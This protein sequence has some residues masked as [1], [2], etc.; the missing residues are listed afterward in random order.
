[1]E[2]KLLNLILLLLPLW[3]IGQQCGA[4]MTPLSLE[5]RVNTAQKIVEGRIIESE[6]YWDANR[7]NIYTVYTLDIYKQITSGSETTV[8]VVTMGG[9]VD[10]VIQTVSDAAVFK[11]GDTG[12][13]FLQSF[14][15]N[16]SATGQL[17]ELVGAAQGVVKYSRFS[18]KASDVFTTYNSIENDLYTS[19]QSIRRSNFQTLKERPIPNAP[20]RNAAAPAISSFSPATATAGTETVLTINGNNFGTTMGT[21]NFPDANAGGAQYDN[22]LDSQIISWSDTQIQVE[23]PGFAGTGAFIVT[24]SDAESGT[25]ASALTITYSHTNSTTPTTAYPDILPNDDGNGGFSFQYHTEFDMSAAKPFFEEAYGIWNCESDINFTISAV[26]PIDVTANDGINV[27]RF[28]NGAELPSTTLGRVTAYAVVCGSKAA[29]TEMDITWNDDTNWYYGNGTPPAPQYDFKTVALHELGHTHRLGHVINSAVVMHYSIG[30]G[31]TK[32]ALDQNDIDGALYTMGLFTGTPECAVT[33]MSPQVNCCDAIVI[34]EQPQD[35]IIQSNSSSPLTV[36]ATGYDSVYW[37]VSNDEG[38]NWNTVTEGSNYANVNTTTLLISQADFE[39]GY[40]HRAVLSNVCGDTVTSNAARTIVF[41]DYTAIPDDNFEAALTALGRD[42]AAG[43]NRVPTFMIDDLIDLNVNN[44]GISDLTG[45]ADFTALQS[46]SLND[47]S[48]TTLDLTGISNLTVVAA[49]NNGLTSIDVSTHPNMDVILVENNNL[50][51]IN[52][53]SNPNLTRLWAQ[54]N[55]FNTL[56]V[57]SNPLLRA[58]GATNGNLTSLDLTLNTALEQLYIAGNAI[59]DLNLSLNEV[60]SIIRVENNNLSSL[61]VK[62]GNNSNVTNFNAGGNPLLTCILVDDANYSTTNWT[63]IDGQT[64]F[65]DTTCSIYTAIPDANFEAALGDLVFDDDA[66]DG[67][68]PTASIVSLTTLNVSSKSIEDLTGIEDF[69]ALTELNIVDNPITTLDLTNN[70]QLQT[71]HSTLCNIT[72]LDITGLTALSTLNLNSNEL[73]SIDLSA[74][75]NLEVVELRENNL[76]E[77]NLRNGANTSITSIDLRFN[78]NL[79]CVLVDDVT[80]S[81]TNWT[82]IDSQTN[83]TA[84]DY[85]EYT[86]IPD[87]NFETALNDLGYDDNLGDALVPTELISGLTT[88]TVDSKGISNLTGIEDFVSLTTLNASYNNL[89]TVDLSN[90]V[91]LRV[92]RM[93]NN[94]FTTVDLSANTDLRV[95]T[96]EDSGLTSL[97]LRANTLIGRL[98]LGGNNLTEMDL[99]NN[100]VLVVVGVNYNN[101]SYLNVRNGNNTN[102]QTFVASNNPNLT[103]IE[104]DDAAYSTSNW[105]SIDPQTSFTDGYCSFSPIPGINF[106]NALGALGLDNTAGDHQ[107]PTSLINGIASLDVSN[108][109]ISNLSGIEAFVSLETLN[110]SDNQISS[111]DISAL[112]LLKNLYANNN[113]LSML[114]LQN[115]SALERLQVDGNNLTAINT[116]NLTELIELSVASNDLNSINTAPNTNLEVLNINNNQIDEI[117]LEDNLSLRSFSAQGNILEQIDLTA[118][119]ALETILLNNNSLRDANFKN[120]NNTNITTFGLSG[121]SQLVCAFVDDAAYSTANWTDVDAQLVF[122]DGDYCE[123]TAIPDP[124]FEAFLFNMGYDDAAGDGRVPTDLIKDVITL[125]MAFPLNPIE[126]LTGIEDFAALEELNING[127]D[128]TELDLTSN[129]NL[130]KLFCESNKFSSFNVTGLTQLEEIECGKS[131]ITSLDV[132]TNVNLRKLDCHETRLSTLD[133]SALPLLV[134]L[135]CSLNFLTH[136]NIQNGNN[137]NFTNFDATN[138]PNLFCVVVDDASNVPMVIGTNVDAQV[139]F[140]DTYCRYTAIPDRNFELALHAQ[141]YDDD[142]TDVGRVPTALIED[143]VTLNVE[144]SDISDLTGIADFKALGTLLCTG[145]SLTTLDLSANANLHF[146][147]CNKN[148]LT[149]LDLSNNPLLTLVNASENAITTFDGTGLAAL[150]QLTLFSNQLTTL[151]VSDM[152]SL[153]DLDL[154][155]NSLTSIDVSANESLEEITV[156]NNDITVMDLSNNPALRV[157]NVRGNDLASIDIKNGNNTNITAFNARNNPN[158]SCILVDDAAYSTTNWTNIDAQTSFNDIV[159]DCEAPSI[160]CTDITVNNDAGVCDANLTIPMPTVSD[161]NLGCVQNDDLESYTVGTLL[162]QGGDWETWNPGTASESFEISTEQALSGTK[163]VKAEGVASGGPTNM[164]YNLGNRSFGAWEVTAHLYIPSGNTATM[165]IQKSETSGT[166]SLNGIQFNSNGVA[167]YRVNDTYTSFSF[168]QDTWFEVKHLVN[169]DGDYAEFFI[170]NQSIVSHPFSHAIDSINGRRTLGSI[171]FFPITN[172]YGNDPNSNAIPLFYIDDVSLCPVTVND[173]NNTTDASGIYPTGTTDVVWSYTDEGGNVA[174]CTQ[175]ITVNDA[176]APQIL[177]CPTDITVCDATVNYEAPLV[178]D[179]CL[180][181]TNLSGYTYLGNFDNKAYYLSDIE[182]NALDA[183]TAAEAQNGFVATIIS[184]EH[185]D[186]LRNA[187]DDVG[188]TTVLIGHTDRDVEGTFGW[189]SGSTATYTNWNTNEP[190]DAGAGEDYVE[191]RSNGLWNDIRSIR[192]RRFVIE[193]EGFPMTQIAGLPSGSVFPVGTTTNTFEATDPAGN[194][195]TCSFDVTVAACTDFSLALKVFLQGPALNPNTGEE[196][197]MRDDL[198]VAGVL[199][200]TSPYTDGL[201]CDASVFDTTGDNA[202]VDWIWIEL[203]DQMDNTVVSYSRSALLQRDGDVVDVDGTSALDF[204][205]IDNTYYVALNHRNHL[206]VMWKN[207]LTFNSDITLLNTLNAGNNFFYGSNARTSFGMPFET[208]GMW[209]GDANNDGEIVF[210]NTGAESVDIKQTVLDVSAVESPFGASVFYK[211]QGYYN[212]D[213][214]MD[215]EVIFLNAGNELLFI[216]DNVLVHPNNQIFNSVFFKIVEQLPFDIFARSKK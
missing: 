94:N 127:H 2:R 149:S 39:Q 17:Y 190:N 4:L 27:V 193:I 136:L 89:S 150:N 7:R 101:L 135:D 152:T 71:L 121:N 18:N 31:Q 9:Q 66:G 212:A 70:T 104:V 207:A 164:V 177:N 134:D 8:K 30:F 26:T 61:N 119:T 95:L 126:N 56:D 113:T 81:E 146:L 211:P 43:D 129:L 45:I 172:T 97:D 189:H 188:G 42:N 216:K 87:I 143:L 62:N 122:R 3:T 151:D 208:F 24:N 23:I 109:S 105:T 171:N 133:V 214:N 60:L 140:R 191:M 181:N 114:D 1:M 96:L 203:R 51:G 147:R 132:S 107:V 195:V 130:K 124:N 186:W 180:A 125:D 145:N 90:N 16:I 153:L 197:L 80:Y 14:S 13:F 67:Q 176:A 210:L 98:F 35:M 47:N 63:S 54:N 139:D 83:F 38:T 21:V 170:D 48:V 103:C 37:E 128:L 166:E 22:V 100:T 79:T 148:A 92:L 184:Q 123:Y 192:E 78:D 213:V 85:C 46:L 40:L 174:T 118:N 84:T 215:G 86:A 102:I 182:S 204:T 10:D 68:I 162:E 120:G 205:T 11:S 77:L 44:Q 138:N 175:V 198:R 209:A 59:T 111:I 141:G 50:A 29:I 163:S 74:F 168:P 64:S 199:P 185:N 155:G 12:M 142:D 112:V 91:L 53:S 115:N 32:Y 116:N 76:T 57:R 183:F 137:V 202:I 88:L 28:D 99:S 65:S 158:L 41:D 6:S 206:G 131:L 157:V 5:D 106:E 15:G 179:N 161:N 169:I 156:E 167:D 72:T 165:N 117:Y 73:S 178:S 144:N 194:T 33:P 75:P 36:T 154:F 58:I 19:V 160:V 69:F 25:S 52:L 173:L 187:L 159:L 34:T 110:V 200:T 108:Q 49:R 82:L 93:R 196:N 20:D 55:N 201:T